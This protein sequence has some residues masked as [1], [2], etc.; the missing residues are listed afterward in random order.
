MDS[1]LL[2]I[3]PSGSVKVNC[4]RR[5]RRTPDR[6]E[7]LCQLM[8]DAQK[9]NPS[10]CAVPGEVSGRSAGALDGCGEPEVTAH[11]LLPQPRL[12]AAS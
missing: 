12:H 2:G 3:E 7:G 5:T 6:P 4:A 9:K 8:G 11:Y 10:V 1:A